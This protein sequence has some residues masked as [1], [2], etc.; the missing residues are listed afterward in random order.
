M[1]RLM[2]SEVFERNGC[3]GVGCDWGVTGALLVVWS[4]ATQVAAF[5]SITPKK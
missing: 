1:V 3:E 5:T 4:A 2:K